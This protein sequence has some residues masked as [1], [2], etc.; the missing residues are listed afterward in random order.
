M[1]AYRSA[2]PLLMHPLDLRELIETATVLSVS[3]TRPVMH[4]LDLRE[5]IETAVIQPGDLESALWM[6][7]AP[8]SDLVVVAADQASSGPSR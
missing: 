6:F 5:L 4:P 8:Q 3:A 7:T 1:P 2:L